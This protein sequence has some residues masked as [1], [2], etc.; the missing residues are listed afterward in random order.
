MKNFN[1]FLKKSGVSLANGGMVEKLMFSYNPTMNVGELVIFCQ[2][3]H[4]QIK[5]SMVK[6]NLPKAG[7][8][9]N[10]PEQSDINLC[11]FVTGWINEEENSESFS[12]TI[13]QER[14]TKVI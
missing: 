1:V 2:N 6:H 12:I 7:I 3:I 13:L 11:R 5:A 14:M 4:Q 8:L 9:L 10:Y